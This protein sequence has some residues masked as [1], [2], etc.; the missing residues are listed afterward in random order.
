[1]KRERPGI[2]DILESSKEESD[3]LCSCWG[4]Y[5]PSYW[6]MDLLLCKKL[7]KECVKTNVLSWGSLLFVSKAFCYILQTIND[8]KGFL[9]FK[10]LPGMN[11]RLNRYFKPH[12]LSK[13]SI[14]LNFFPSFTVLE[15]A[16]YIKP[17]IQ[18]E[19]R[20]SKKK[21]TDFQ[22]QF[23]CP[24][25]GPGLRCGFAIGGKIVM[26]VNSVD[27]MDRG[28]I[29][30]IAYSHP[31]WK[32]NMECEEPSFPHTMTVEEYGVVHE[33]FDLVCKWLFELTTFSI[34]T[35]DYDHCQYLRDRSRYFDHPIPLEKGESIDEKERVNLID[36]FERSAH[37]WM[38]RAFGDPTCPS[39][40]PPL[41]EGTIPS[42][43]K[44]KPKDSFIKSFVLASSSNPLVSELGLDSKRMTAL[45]ML[46]I[47]EYIENERARETSN[48][49][50]VHCCSCHSS[51]RRDSLMRFIKKVDKYC[52]LSGYLKYWIGMA[53]MEGL[54][55]ARWFFQTFR[56][57]SIDGGFTSWKGGNRSELGRLAWIESCTG[58]GGAISDALEALVWLVFS[59]LQM[60]GHFKSLQALKEYTKN[61][62]RCEELFRSIKRLCK[63]NVTYANTINLIFNSSYIN[64]T[65]VNESEEDED[66]GYSSLLCLAF[67]TLL[68]TG[69]CGFFTDAKTKCIDSLFSIML[70]TKDG[71]DGN[72]N[73]RNNSSTNRL[74]TK[75]F[76]NRYAHTYDGD[77]TCSHYS[78][79]VGFNGPPS[80]FI[81]SNMTRRSD[82]VEL[83]DIAN[84]LNVGKKTFNFS[85]HVLDSL[86]EETFEELLFDS[87]SNTKQLIN[88]FFYYPGSYNTGS[89][90][91]CAPLS[92]IYGRFRNGDGGIENRLSSSCW[93]VLLKKAVQI[94]AAM[95]VIPEDINHFL[96]T[97]AF[98]LVKDLCEPKTDAMI[99]M[100]PLIR[101]SKDEI[102]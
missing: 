35:S 71:N 54:G 99:M 85:R 14:V 32:G 97:V 73:I 94:D 65:K 59:P 22:V 48:D 79:M 58:R 15:N 10:A 69:D 66:K 75:S 98:M 72:P 61:E 57:S 17:L 43:P 62:P 52:R 95:E 102:A 12:P 89:Y 2:N 82:N 92:L 26:V 55:M 9:Y 18:T 29:E 19:E 8:P 28:E 78:Y 13:R 53:M 24:S 84:V 11:Q 96:C 100:A 93:F 88:I 56:P 41:I 68:G 36:Q 40:F 86:N 30:P 45:V 42:F 20:E 6:N 51:Y 63:E 34:N 49:S 23:D 83:R 64:Q 101:S 5:V 16:E 38:C 37:V 25:N 27:P 44:L 77:M 33:R 91:N 70:T 76:E 80:L 1:M 90:K 60:E 50:V 39:C 7:L 81:D 47:S 4:G 74:F 87:C 46:K 67:R 21:K 31:H 3:I